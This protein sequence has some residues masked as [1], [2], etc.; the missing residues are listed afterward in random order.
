M[1]KDADMSGRIDKDEFTKL[2]VLTL[3]MD[4]KEVEPVWR[5]VNVSMDD[6]VEFTEFIAAT[7][8]F[9]SVDCARMVWSKM[10]NDN[11]KDVSFNEFKAFMHDM[12]ININE[13]KMMDIFIQIDDDKNNKLTLQEFERYFEREFIKFEKIE[14]FELF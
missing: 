1:S 14:E 3:G 12:S 6:T 10:D 13:D 9:K 2:L 4:P 7:A 5:A 8:T 11:S